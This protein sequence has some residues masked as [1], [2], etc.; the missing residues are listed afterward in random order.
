MFDPCPPGYHVI[1]AFGLKCIAYDASS[2]LNDMIFNDGYMYHKRDTDLIL[3]YDGCRT[4]GTKN[5]YAT[6]ATQLQDVGSKPYYWCASYF[7]KAGQDGLALQFTTAEVKES[8][9]ATEAKSMT[10][11]APVKLSKSYAC[12]VRAQKQM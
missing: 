1:S 11:A 2:K 3:P 5:T 7:N 4:P 6:K 10:V 12:S 9:D 8:K